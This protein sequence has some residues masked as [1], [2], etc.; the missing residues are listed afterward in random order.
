[1]Y[2]SYLFIALAVFIFSMFMLKSHIFSRA[3]AY[4]G[5]LAGA[6]DLVYCIGIIFL[7]LAQ[8]DLIAKITQPAAGLLL[9]IWHILIGV[10][11]WRL[12]SDASQKEPLHG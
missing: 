4:S 5:I 3:T 7:P 12:A 8:I 1:M 9:M 11:L 10:R 6:L 2:R